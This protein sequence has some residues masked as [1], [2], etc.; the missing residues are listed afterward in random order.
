MPCSGGNEVEGSAILKE[1]SLVTDADDMAAHKTVRA[2]S[3]D[4]E[5]RNLLSLLFKF[6]DLA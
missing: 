5:S 4:R 3:W 6:L 1:L 2:V